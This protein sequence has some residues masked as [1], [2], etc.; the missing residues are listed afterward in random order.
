MSHKILI[1]DDEIDICRLLSGFLEKKGYDCEYTGK[2]R[3]GLKMIEDNEFDLIICDFRLPDMDGLE[4]IRSIRKLNQSVK[5][6]VITGYSDVKMAVQVIKLGAFEYVT[7]PIYP[8]EILLTIKKALA[9]QDVELDKTTNTK[10]STKQKTNGKKTT[11]MEGDSNA[12]KNLSQLI[13]LLAPTNMSV[14]IEGESGVGKEVVANRIHDESER[15]AKSFEAIDCGALPPELAGSELF[16]HI[17]GSFTG[18]INNKTG[19]FQMAEGGT[20]FLDEVG[21]LSYDNQIKLLRVLQER[22]IRKIGDTKDIEVDVRLIAASNDSL[23]KLVEEGRFREDLYYRINEF[24]V[25][26]PALR[27][28]RSDIKLFADVFLKE[29]NQDLGRNVKAFSDS[30]LK[31]LQTY[32]WPGNIREL[33]NVI[34]RGVLLSEGEQMSVDVLPEEVIKGENSVAA[35]QG[36]LADIDIESTD[37]KSISEKAEKAAILKTLENTNY[38]KTKTA[39]ILNIDRKT[40]YNKM[41]SYQ[42]DSKKPR[43]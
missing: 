29:A 9:G 37:L 13:K 34:K 19:H 27:D 35:T 3:K 4:L 14:L 21:N 5:V 20:L 23:E 25:E 18:A 17:K 38:N 36:M 22:K 39:K 28:R 8:E 11:F 10:K 33:K 41:D 6:I 40:L 24:L 43:Q 15:S 30:C 32:E 42:I 31:A 12:S 16:G 26:V 1:I 2:A 7:K